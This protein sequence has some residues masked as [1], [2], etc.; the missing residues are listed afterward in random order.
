MFQELLEFICESCCGKRIKNK[1]ALLTVE[2]I[3]LAM[4]HLPRDQFK[5]LLKYY[6]KTRSER[7]LCDRNACCCLVKS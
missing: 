7:E 6:V 5:K 3:V 2:D 1:R 4:E